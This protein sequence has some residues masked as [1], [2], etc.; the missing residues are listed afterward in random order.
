MALITTAAREE[1]IAVFTALFRAAPGATNLNSMVAAYENGATTAQIAASLALR[2]EFQTTYPT[3]QTADE[4]AASLISTMLPSTTPAA[5][6]AWATQWI[7]GQLAA[8]KSRA[9]IIT[10]AVVAI[11]ATTNTNYSDAKTLLANKVDVATY[12]SVTQLQSSTSLAALQ[13]V[14]VG[15]TT[16]AST[17]TAAKTAVD[18]NV[19]DALGVVYTLTTGVDAIKGN[20]GNDTINAT[21]DTTNSTF[22][23]LDSVDG[24]AGSKDTFNINSLIDF[25]MPAAVTVSNVEQ[26]GIAAAGKVG[27]FT[28]DGAGNLDL[29]TAFGGITSL[30]ISGAPTAV[31]IKAP[32]T[33]AVTIAGSA[34]GGV[35]VVNGTTQTVTLATQGGALKLSGASGAINVTSKSQG[36][37]TVTVDDGTTVT[38]NGGIN[39]TAAT[40]QGAITIGATKVGTGA[41][42]VTNTLVNAA[43][44][45]SSGGTVTANG[46]GATISVA[47]TATQAAATAAGVNNHTGQGKVVVN[48]G[49][50]FTSATVTQSAYTTAIDTAVAVAPVV[51]VNTATFTALTAGQ[52]LI[53]GGLTFTAGAAGT[54]KEE[55]AAAFASLTPGASQG[56]S[57]KGTYSGTWAASST[58]AGFT[59]GAAS[60]DTVVFT[61]TT[62]NSFNSALAI[63]ANNAKTN[64]A[65]TGTGTATIVETVVGVNQVLA[66]G[67]GGVTQGTVEIDD[68]GAEVDTLSTATITGYAANSFVKSDALTTLN[69]AKN[70]TNASL[71]V[72]N[73]AA[74]SLTLNLDSL[75][76]G[77]TINLD[78]AGAKYT[79][80]TVNV[81]TSLTPAANSTANITGA[82]VKALVVDGTRTL[83]ATGSTFT[84]LE[85]LTVKGAAG[86]TADLSAPAG[87]TA[88]DTTATTGTSTLTID[89][90]KA[91][92]TGGAGVDAVTT[93][94]VAPTKNI[95]LGGGDDSL[96]LVSGT[97]TSTGVL[98]GGAGT[99]TLRMVV[100]DAVTASATTGFQGSFDGF[101]KLA[102]VGV[103]GGAAGTVNVANMDNINY[104][105]SAPQAAVAAATESFTL[106]LAGSSVKTGDTVIFAGTTITAGA[107]DD[108]IAELATAII[109]GAFAGWTQAA[110][111][112]QPNQVKFTSTTATTNITDVTFADFT[113]NWAGVKTVSVTQ[114]SAGTAVSGMPTIDKLASGGTVEFAGGSSVGA[115]VN[116]ADAATG[117][118]DV[119]NLALRSNSTIAVGTVT[120]ADVETITIAN[121]DLLPSSLSGPDN[122][123]SM[124]LT[125]DK[126]TSVTITGN[127]ALTLTMTGSTKVATIN[128]SALTGAL[129]VTSVNTTS[130]TTITGGS[131]NDTLKASVGGNTA[132]VLIGGA[133]TDSLYN[134]SGLNQLTGGA[135]DDSFYITTASLNV[136]SYA[137]I[138]DPT[139]GDYI[140][141]T[142]TAG[143]EVF[144]A[145]KIALGDTAVFQDY[146]NAAIVNNTTQGGISWFQYGGNTYIVQEAL[147]NA[148]V[149]FTNNTDFIVKLTGLVDLT[150]ASFD[151]TAAAIS[152]RIG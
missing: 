132:D 14:I 129:T 68:T 24:G 49:A 7:V 59:S 125:A 10:E 37:N 140:Y 91:K 8:G 108:T 111:A 79:A 9:Q 141:F 145:S 55:S 130:A 135:G 4:F 144:N 58:T 72:H 73:T 88:F 124:T 109:G 93:S 32:S 89:A 119:L 41:V 70:T 110:V 1:L 104:V 83:T 43:G 33:A 134:N 13:N 71:A 81:T 86:I 21:I 117:T 98:S 60:G 92:Y 12:Y 44:A 18:G 52:T 101:E 116:I 25:A 34:T 51:E 138:T 67:R 133:G 146:A 137:T 147:A 6:V 17:V 149:I 148:D 87:M 64:L 30:T 94:A 61:G 19:A 97:T 142:D 152:V 118:A 38:V 27:T 75:A 15:V 115:T 63:V 36:T 128:G 76:A 2:S 47:Q 105:I 23:G 78:A 29:S 46:G 48:G 127:T 50:G 100:A 151:N 112:G 77:S 11:R 95:D 16:A 99:D 53:I 102:L 126:A 31:D 136:N 107:T 28:A 96:T 123:N 82:A 22:T 143:A 3:L 114:G 40:A 122:A 39:A 80:L 90:T 66:A 45:D 120:A 85:T 103:A 56:Y 35:E 57:T 139:K 54:T 106:T 5:A 121:T 20:A 26:V 74:T 65:N 150:L 42:T 62:V 131:G 84:A 69:L 113:G